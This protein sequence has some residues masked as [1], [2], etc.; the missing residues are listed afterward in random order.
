MELKNGY[1]EYIDIN[2]IQPSKEI[3]V[4]VLLKEKESLLKSLAEI[5]RLLKAAL[6]EN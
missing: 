3:S 5:D 4:D 2:V 1:S 6:D